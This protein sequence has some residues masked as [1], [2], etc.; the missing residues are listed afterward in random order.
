MPVTRKMAEKYRNMTLEEI[1]TQA[2]ELLKRDKRLREQE[3]EIE[4][5][6][7]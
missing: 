6:Y 5:Q 7:A 1:A 2:E 3:L 4:I